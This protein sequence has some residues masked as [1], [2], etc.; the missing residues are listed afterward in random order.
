MAAK[1]LENCQAVHGF[2]VYSLE[3]SGNLRFFYDEESHSSLKHS[4]VPKFVPFK[5][6]WFLCPFSVSLCS[7]P[8]L[9]L[10]IHT[11][12]GFATRLKSV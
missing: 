2:Y 8:R 7:L 12:F 11:E 10:S 5:P 3:L 6:Y 1:F 9:S 4:S